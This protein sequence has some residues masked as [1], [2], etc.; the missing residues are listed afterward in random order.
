MLID[1]KD[2][3]VRERDIDKIVCIL[4]WMLKNVQEPLVREQGQEFFWGNGISSLV[5]N[6]H[7]PIQNLPDPSRL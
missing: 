7:G 1:K 2:G 4:L 6:V 3:R 5:S